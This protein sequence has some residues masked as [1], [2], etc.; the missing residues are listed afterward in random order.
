[1]KLSLIVASPGK[2]NQWAVAITRPFFV[3]GRE[4][5]CQLRPISDMVSKHHCALLVGENAAFVHDLG[6]TNGTFVNDQQVRDKTELH[7]RDSLRVGPLLFTV[8]LEA[9]LLDL[10]KQQQPQASQ[11]T[12]DDELAAALLLSMPDRPKRRFR[13]GSGGESASP[14]AETRVDPGTTQSGGPASEP[15]KKVAAH[16]KVKPPK[17]DMGGTALVAKKI[18]KKHQH[19]DTSAR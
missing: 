19:S 12:A 5:D 1:M 16:D 14:A 13:L 6:S 7:D 2:M 9:G 18:L 11:E 15:K 4:A 8:R 10:P 17:P 3:I